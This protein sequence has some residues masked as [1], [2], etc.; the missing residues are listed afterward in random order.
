MTDISHLLVDDDC[1]GA[2]LHARA[3]LDP[4]ADRG[5]GTHVAIDRLAYAAQARHVVV[6]REA[7]APRRTALGQRSVEIADVGLGVAEDR[8]GVVV[9]AVGHDRDLDHDAAS[10][11]TVV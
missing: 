10:D 9:A 3:G 6:R 5:L 11:P 2:C 4:M 7:E 8:G 1:G